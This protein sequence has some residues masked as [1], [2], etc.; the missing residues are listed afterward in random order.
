MVKEERHHSRLI[1]NMTDKE[2]DGVT[3]IS[4]DT[5]NRTHVD[6]CDPQGCYERYVTYTGVLIQLEALIDVSVR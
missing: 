1:C 5:E 2:G 4:H 3:V 6:G